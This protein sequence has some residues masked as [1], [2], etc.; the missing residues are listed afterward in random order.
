MELYELAKKYLMPDLASSCKEFLKRN[1]NSFNFVEVA[2]WAEKMKLEEMF[3]TI[4]DFCARSEDV[5]MES[6]S[7]DSLPPSIVRKTISKMKREV[8]HWKKKAIDKSEQL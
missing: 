8:H 4:A 1:L 5:D 2:L 3:E 7:F 6:D